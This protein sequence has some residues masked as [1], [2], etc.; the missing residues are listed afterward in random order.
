MDKHLTGKKCV[1]DLLDSY[2]SVQFSGLEL[3][4][5]VKGMT[6][7]YFYP[8]TL[9]RYVREYRAKTGRKVV[10][11]DKKKSLYRVVA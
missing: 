9:L 7:Q 1:F 2:D 8:D 3:Q 4:K 11:V 10:N 5:A 6:G